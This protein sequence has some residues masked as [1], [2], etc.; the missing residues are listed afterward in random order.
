MTFNRSLKDLFKDVIKSFLRTE[1]DEALGRKKY[2][3]GKNYK[4]S[5]W[6]YSKGCKK[7]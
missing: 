3:I 4:F 6:I 5:K 7:N 2:D 1:T